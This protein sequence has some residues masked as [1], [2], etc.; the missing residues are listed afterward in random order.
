MEAFLIL[1]TSVDWIGT[2]LI[3]ILLYFLIILILKMLYRIS[4][5]RLEIIN[6]FL[7]HLYIPISVIILTA[8]FLSIRPFPN[9]IIV[10]LLILPFGKIIKEMLIG[11]Y[12]KFAG[13]HSIGNE[14]LLS[15]QK[16]KLVHLEAT[17][18]IFQI[19]D[20]RLLVPYSELNSQK[21]Q[22]IYSTNTGE[23]V[24]FL[25]SIEDVEG[26]KNK[27][28]ILNI[29]FNCPFILNHQFPSNTSNEIPTQFEVYLKKGIEKMT[30]LKYFLKYFKGITIEND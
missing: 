6:R 4:D 2:L 23:K 29:L 3:L 22:Q 10:L 5:F 11:Q 14:Y 7:N 17:N 13:H 18:A 20:N 30:V 12:I 28:Q 8:V 15:N 19:G 25:L 27:N 24:R 16:A 21:V 9:A 26:I 1:S